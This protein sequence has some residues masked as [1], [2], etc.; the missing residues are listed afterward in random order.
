MAIP[1]SNIIWS[2]W[3]KYGWP[4]HLARIT[5]WTSAKFSQNIVSVFSYPCFHPRE[6]FLNGIKIGWICR[7]IMKTPPTLFY[8]FLKTIEVM[9]TCVIEDKNRI[10]LRIRI[11]LI[12]EN[13]YKWMKVIG[14]PW[15]S[16][17]IKVKYSI[18]TDC[19]KN[20]ISLSSH[21]II[22]PAR[23]FADW[24]PHFELIRH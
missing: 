23:P 1:T 20:W 15:S 19:W 18:Q 24:R 3:L 16:Q 12:K 2:H 4:Q 9:S 8:H 11:H 14:C 7:Q 17:D 6:S 13:I 22:V 10:F 21:K 5:S